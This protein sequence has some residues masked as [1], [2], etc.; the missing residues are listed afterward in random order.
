MSESLSNV[1]AITMFIEDV[2]RS[3][4]FYQRVFEVEPIYEDDDAIAFRL[5]NII[6]NLLKRAAAVELIEPAAP[7][8]PHDGARFQLTLG[9]ENVDDA[10]RDLADRGVTL[11]NGPMDRPWGIR[12]AAFA[13]PDGHI[14]E[15]AHNL[16]QTG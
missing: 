11:L 4:E 14:W 3:K 15:M 2:A 10:C 8:L 16:S 5:E 7:G 1:D 9:V 12:T 13:D 6:V